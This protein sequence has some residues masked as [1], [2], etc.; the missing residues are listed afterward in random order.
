MTTRANQTSLPVYNV[1]QSSWPTPMASYQLL[2]TKLTPQSTK[3]KFLTTLGASANRTNFLK[4]FTVW[5][6]WNFWKSW[7]LLRIQQAAED[8]AWGFFRS[9]QKDWFTSFEL[10]SNPCTLLVLN[11][12]RQ[13]TRG[14]LQEAARRL[15]TYRLP[16]NHRLLSSTGSFVSLAM[17]LNSDK[18]AHAR[19][20]L[21][22]R[23]R[24]TERETERESDRESKN[25]G[26]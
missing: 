23:E 11:I 22:E 19:G 25:R 18:I 7:N 10:S 3:K 20:L 9:F 1:V 14:S 24:V 21:W 5:N 17:R 15:Q 4:K 26:V 12:F 16:I 6:I 13:T 8:R 2:Y